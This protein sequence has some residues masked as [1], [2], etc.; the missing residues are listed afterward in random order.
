MQTDTGRATPLSSEYD[1]PIPAVPINT[2]AKNEAGKLLF[3]NRLAFLR[4]ERSG[5]VIEKK[6]DIIFR[7]E[8]NKCKLF[9]RLQRCA[10][11]E[12]KKVL[13]THGRLPLRR[14]C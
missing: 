6:L 5:D 8:A 10:K 4:E 13:G 3:I 9:N 7:N 14:A 1:S 12:P 2:E 11:N